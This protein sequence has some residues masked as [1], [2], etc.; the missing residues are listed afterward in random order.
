[1]SE[2]LEARDA[3]A[4][5]ARGGALM[6][7]GVNLSVSAG[8]SIGIVGESGSGK[9]TVSRML[10]GL[11]SPTVGEVLVHGRPWSTV[12]RGDPIRRLVQMV[13]QDPYGSLNP[14]MRV[15]DAV[16]EP[17]Q[18]WHQ[19]DRKAA[20]ARAAE[21]LNETGLA[22]AAMARRPGDLSGGQCQRVGIARALACEPQILIADEPTSAL[23][24]SVQAQILN[25]LLRLRRERGL[26]LVLVSH[27]LAVVR[28]M[29]EHALVM[30]S[31]R[32]VEQGPTKDLLESPRHPYTRV[33][34][35]SIPGREG[36]AVAVRNEVAPDH[37]CVFAHRCPKLQD[38]CAQHPTSLDGGEHGVMCAFPLRSS[39]EY[40]NAQEGGGG[41]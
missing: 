13:F 8:A 2:L 10:V 23:D 19:V 25:L 35:D 39:S 28:Y 6:A 34:V 41:R 26:A 11:L 31:G 5:Y 1:M 12:K 15:I 33:L 16:A 29:T 4:S 14:L 37:W 21:L 22:E 30:N 38:A 9:T 3:G 32:V 24:V 7:A 20:L 40:S 17:V 27:D 18:Y 36:P